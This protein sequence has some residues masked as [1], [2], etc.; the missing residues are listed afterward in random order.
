M[1]KKGFAA[2]YMVYS[3]FLIFILTMITVLLVNN[4]K[5]DFL[6]ALKKD[7]KEGLK[8]EKLEVKGEIIPEIGENSVN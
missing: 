6:N 2:T 4:Y 3:L 7:I 5:S 1:N 8:E